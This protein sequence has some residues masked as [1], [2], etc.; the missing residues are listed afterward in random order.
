MLDT[1]SKSLLK[2]EFGTADEDTVIK[3]ILN[4]GQPQVK[5]VCITPP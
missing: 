1:A 5:T 2:S 3:K 4:E